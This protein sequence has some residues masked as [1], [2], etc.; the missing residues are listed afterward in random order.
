M[1]VNCD[2]PMN[3]ILAVLCFLMAVGSAWRGARLLGQGLRQA[4]HPCGALW[5][6]RGLRAVII[7]IGIAALGGGV[8]LASK[9]LL[10]FG[11]LFLGEEL[12]ET[13]VVLLA[14]RAQLKASKASASVARRSSGDAHLVLM[15]PRHVRSGPAS[16]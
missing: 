12:Y 6:V 16:V 14:L 13:G 9:G 15:P 7:A 3:L 8:L 10:V 2:P 11:A 1:G 4:G 5:V